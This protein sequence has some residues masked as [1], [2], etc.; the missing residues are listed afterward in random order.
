MKELKFRFFSEQDDLMRY[1]G[2]YD[3]LNAFFG[4][5]EFNK[6]KYSPRIHIMQYTGLKDKNGTEGYFDDLAKWGKA[7]YQIAWNEDDGIAWLKYIKGKEVFAS[8]RISQL[9]HG[10]VISN[11]YENPELLK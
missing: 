5:Y 8:L 10:E 9:K 4:H 1:S 2:T 3:S 7:I 6:T 11:I